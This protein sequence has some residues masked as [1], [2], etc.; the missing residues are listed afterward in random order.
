[1]TE[2][3]SI[4]D[5]LAVFQGLILGVLLIVIKKNRKSSMFLGLFLITYVLEFIPTMLFD[6]RDV[7]SFSPY[8]LPLYF[9]MGNMPLFYI[10]CRKL[11]GGISG[12]TI[13]IHLI[14][15]VIEF[16][17][18]LSLLILDYKGLINGN[19]LFSKYFF[20]YQLSAILYSLAYT[21]LILLLLKDYRGKA[22]NY[23]SKLDGNVLLWINSIVYFIFIFYSLHFVISFILIETG[24]IVIILNSVMSVLNV[25]FIYWIGLSGYRQSH[26]EMMC[27]TN[28]E[29][30]LEDSEHNLAALFSDIVDYFNK[31]KPYINTDFTLSSLSIQMNENVKKI[32]QAINQNTNENFNTFVNKYRVEETKRILITDKYKNFSI[33][34]I[35]FEAGFN[36]KAAFYNAFKKFTKATPVQFRETHHN[37]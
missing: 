2:L 29:Q 8:L 9:Y 6:I 17:C 36:S 7:W 28:V 21:V 13:L 3:L 20:F 16:I 12:K 22:V 32:S 11:V 26:K 4:L 19:E 23:Y 31:D 15:A 5:L 10:Y 30:G 24:A 1:M 33:L 14:P 37:K 34:A 25:A 18:L 35:G 27:I